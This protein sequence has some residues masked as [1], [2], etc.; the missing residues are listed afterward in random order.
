MD[1]RFRLLK[2]EDNQ[3]TIVPNEEATAVK[4]YD[5]GC[6]FKVSRTRPVIMNEISVTCIGE[7]GEHLLKLVMCCHFEV[8]PSDWDAFVEDGKRILPVP[9][10]C[11]IAS[12]SMGAARG[13]MFERTK[14]TALAQ[15]V[16]P[17]VN[18]ENFIN[19][20]IEIPVE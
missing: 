15:Y 4:S 18:V 8:E 19:R 6:G 2:I 20:Q 14:S 7:K 12:I 5:Y 16:L 3:F 1:T 10:L 17:L 9:F 13:V 11:H